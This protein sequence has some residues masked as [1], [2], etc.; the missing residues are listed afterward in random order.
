MSQPRSLY[1]ENPM[2]KPLS[3]GYSRYSLDFA[4]AVTDY[5]TVPNLTPPNLNEFT[6]MIWF[7]MT[8]HVGFW[9]G[10][11]GDMLGAGY[12]YGA[13]ISPGNILGFAVSGANPVACNSPTPFDATRLN[14]WFC[15][16]M[17]YDAPNMETRININGIRNH[18]VV[19]I[20]A[21]AVSLTSL[22]IAQ[23]NTNTRHFQGPL[24][25]FLFYDRALLDSEIMYNTLNYNEPLKDDLQV[26]Y[27][28]EEGQGNVVADRSGNGNNGTMFGATWHENPKWE[29]RAEAH[30]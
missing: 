9:R 6:F 7:Y 8:G 14:R 5:I 21:P 11:F 20:A 25:E 3:K 17:T 30:L 16:A 2:R 22:R 24:D 23:Q 27:R 4:G 18:T 28:M 26:W 1:V 10:I 29:L 12:Q 13:Y 19:L 15:V